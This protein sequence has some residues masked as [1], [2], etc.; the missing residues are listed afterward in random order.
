MPGS[1]RPV[2]TLQRNDNSLSVLPRPTQ[3]KAFD[4]HEN[5]STRASDEPRAAKRQK[6]GTENLV[7][8]E[9]SGI[10]ID[11]SGDGS[12]VGIGRNISST[13]PTPKKTVQSVSSRSHYQN[14]PPISR[15][16]E[17]DEYNRTEAMVGF[18]P[19][20]RRKVYDEFERRNSF[21]GEMESGPRQRRTSLM[22]EPSILVTKGIPAASVNGIGKNPIL[23]ED[24]EH[25]EVVEVSQAPKSPQ[26]RARNATPRPEANKVPE[27]AETSQYFSS[28]D[29]R[30]TAQNGTPDTAVSSVS[31]GSTAEVSEREEGGSP[32]SAVDEVQFLEDDSIDLVKSACGPVGL[33]QKAESRAQVENNVMK[34]SSTPKSKSISQEGDIPQSAFSGLRVKN[35][36]SQTSRML[37][38]ELNFEIVSMQSGQKGFNVDVDCV[39]W[40]LQYDLDKKEFDI[41]AYDYS[42]R[43]DYQGLV[44]KPEK[45][46]VVKYH[47]DSLKVVI[48]RAMEPSIGAAA[49][50]LVKMNRLGDGN[51]LAQS[52]KKLNHTIKLS[53]LGRLA[54]SSLKASSPTD[55]LPP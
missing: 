15:L 17:V 9:S 6:V 3:K 26:G 22:S 7:R 30:G 53:P 33:D 43:E 55:R 32:G 16:G 47:H 24:L 29:K 46:H 34:A 11:I 2:N 50:V 52:L 35:S 5:N 14:L 44:L 41:L 4:L 51:R 23:I 8:R 18:G 37:K 36:Q 21:R 39:P 28:L 20:K 12:H 54:S 31:S 38:S 49:Q 25:V 48:S 45:I 19:L 40:K 27:T 10:V 1:F 42:V 13:S